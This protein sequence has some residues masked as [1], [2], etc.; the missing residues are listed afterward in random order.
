MVGDM[1]M[2]D[3]EDEALGNPEQEQKAQ[4]AMQQGQQ[5][6]QQVMAEMQ[7]LALENGSLKQ[8]VEEIAVRS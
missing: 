1:G 6:I 2:D 5:Q 8:I 7:Q 3:G 4:Q